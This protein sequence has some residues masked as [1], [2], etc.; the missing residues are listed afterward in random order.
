MRAEEKDKQIWFNEALGVLNTIIKAVNRSTDLE[1]VMATALVEIDAVLG[2]G[3][4]EIWLFDELSQQLSSA[5]QHGL[6]TDLA[7]EITVFDLGAG[8]PGAIAQS[9]EPLLILDLAKEPRLLQQGIVNQHNFRSALGI[10]LMAQDNLVGVIVFFSSNASNFTAEIIAQLTTIGH[11]M[12]TAIQNARL[13]KTTQHYLAEQSALLAATQAISSSLDLTTVLRRLAE[14]MVQAL[15]V[16]SA[17]ICDW[18]PEEETSTVLAEYFTPHVSTAE[19]ISKLGL[20]YYPLKELEQLGAWLQRGQMMLIHTDDPDLSKTERNHLKQHGGLSLLFIPFLVKGEVTGFVQLW[21]SRCRRNFTL[22]ELAL[23]QAIAQQGA[24]ALENARLF[25]QAQREI[26]ERKRAEERLARQAQETFRL[27]EVR[28]ALARELEISELARAVVESMAANFGY[29][30]VVLYL[31]KDDYL[32]LQHQVG[33]RKAAERLVLDRGIQGHIVR[34]GKP[35]LI[36]DTATEPTYIAGGIRSIICVPLFSQGKV[37]GM[38][39]IGSLDGA[40][41]ET[42]LRVMT[43]LSEYISIAFERA[44]LY[45]EARESEEKYRTLIEQ[46]QDAIYLIYGNRF[47]IVNRRF[48]ELFGVT[49][50]DVNDPSFVFTN[51]VA[52]KSRRSVAEQAKMGKSEREDQTPIVSPVYEFTAL[53]K[54]GHEIEV[55][56]S[57]SYPTY[58]GGLATQGILRDISERKRAEAERAAMQAQIFQNAKLASMG[59]L[60]AG[61]AHEINNPIF[62]I[63]EYAALI[64]EDTSKTHSNYPMLETIIGEANRIAEIVRNLLEFARPSEVRFRV[65]HLGEIWQLVQTLVGQSFQEQNI[66]LEVDIPDDLPLIKA[67]R[68]QLQQVLLNLVTNARDALKEKYPGNERH[69]GKRITIKARFIAGVEIPL[70]IDEKKERINQAI[71]LTVRDEGM[72]ISPEHR[73]NLFTPFFT[74]KRHQGGTG[75][76]LSISH[77]IIEEHSGRIDIK[78]EPGEFT[79]FIITLP[80]A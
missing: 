71:Q 61:V 14:Q 72:G 48:R 28:T 11:L 64:L 37:I 77:K 9:R 2:L 60:A 76:G 55:E 4:S 13:F 53:D 79:E 19:R 52:P 54:D 70:L 59:E 22:D 69:P 26:R 5:V 3:H 73:E 12:G 8:L 25:G 63:R 58:K 46:S 49:Q 80:V 18:Q 75:L 20:T 35:V 42:D 36:E 51:I 50:E 1:E 45:T 38:L 68:Q 65:V 30:L 10:P 16:T 15:A 24:V 66:Q 44:Y 40:F 62:A 67:R 33:D 23:C 74:T 27:N 21:E 41:G 34:T 57:V 7:K 31:L 43:M 29:S 47:E 78:S 39:G 6:P 32:V 17:Q 56:L